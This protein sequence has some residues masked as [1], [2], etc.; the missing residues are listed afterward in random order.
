MENSILG[1]GS[2]PEPPPTDAPAYSLFDSRAVALATFLGSPLAG[3]ALM[4]VNYN[5][6]GNSGAAV[7]AVVAGVVSTGLLLYVSFS[8]NS[9]LLNVLP[10][11]LMFLMMRIAKG[12]Q[13]DDVEQHVRQ[14]GKL[15]SRLSAAG[16]GIAAM[17]VVLL[18]VWACLGF[19][20]LTS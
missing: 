6:L 17:A 18:V 10:L 14:G 8:I 4:G 3:C 16:I 7:R 20:P 11:L 19:A 13:G 15:A 5:R 9:S 2:S 12:L 1:T